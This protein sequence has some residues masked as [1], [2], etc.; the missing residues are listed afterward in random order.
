MRTEEEGGERKQCRGVSSPVKSHSAPG[1][2]RVDL[3]WARK[4][5]LSKQRRSPETL[6]HHVAISP[7]PHPSL[8]Q[9]EVGEGWKP[10]D[11]AAEADARC[12][13]PSNARPAP[14]RRAW[15]AGARE[16]GPA[17]HGC[18]GSAAAAP[19]AG[20]FCGEARALSPAWAARRRP[21]LSRNSAATESPLGRS[22][23]PCSRPRRRGRVA[24][25]RLLQLVGTELTV[26]A[27]SKVG[28][29]VHA[30]SL[31]R[32]HQRP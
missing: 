30:R 22:R 10:R 20:G 18:H 21:Q 4:E 14:P 11:R 19:D 9:A 24:A 23:I 29:N 13:S 16:R 31:T 8:R 5:R 32:T 7:H 26:P 27:R 1:S 17:G 2:R 15:S 6:G 28:R 12:R 3:M 25:R